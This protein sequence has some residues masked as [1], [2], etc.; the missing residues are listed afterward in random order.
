MFKKL[1]NNFVLLN[2]IIISSVMIIAFTVIYIFMYQKTFKDL[3][4]RL[5]GLPVGS[6]RFMEN[7]TDNEIFLGGVLPTDYSLSFNLIVNKE[8]QLIR[9][10]SYVDM[11]RETY[12]LAAE[13][14][15][16]SNKEYG[17][18]KLDDRIWMYH[19]R[20]NENLGIRNNFPAIVDSN[21]YYIVF[22]DATDSMNSLNSLL[23]TFIVVGGLMLGVIYIISV[24]FAK[25]NIKGIE[26]AWNKQKQFIAD[27]SHEFKTPI[28]IIDANTDVLL[29][30][31][32][33]KNKK[34]LNYIKA[35]TNRMNKL[36]TNLLYLTKSEN[37]DV[38]FENIPFNISEILN[39]II[40]SMEAIIYEKKITLTQN[41]E[42]S[43]AFKGDASRIEQ[44]MIILI[45]N[46]I[47]YTDESGEINIDL[48]RT[49]KAIEF[50]IEN[51]GKGIES[52]NLPKVF[53]RFYRS[54][55]AR[56]GEDNS[57]G[58]GLSIAKAIVERMNGKIGVESV[59]NEK[60]K[61]TI[62]LKTK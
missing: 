62:I 45:D 60:T 48:K 37:M 19:V 5:T 24:Y 55:T 30:E 51:S 46:A 49:N 61:F 28:A 11:P 20:G 58:L 57:Y 12:Q 8:G 6:P 47:K 59:P 56:T 54:D 43:L 50:S 26:E 16:D 7:P 15:I 1:R 44:V 40:L 13:K 25:R 41:I 32:K 38:E 9:I 39:K 4:D 52:K 21:S 29:I 14:V 18:M 3:Q 35:E 10:N 31:E 27:A 53:D 36:V 42:E 17:K 33:S 22:L 34:W 23:L 2:M